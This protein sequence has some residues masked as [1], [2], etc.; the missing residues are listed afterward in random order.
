VQANQQPKTMTRGA[1]G[2]T[3]QSPL[4]S[5]I[6]TTHA[7]RAGAGEKGLHGSASPNAWNEADSPNSQHEGAEDTPGHSKPFFS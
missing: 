7:A 6:K 3:E 5:G 4:K 2:T 1:A